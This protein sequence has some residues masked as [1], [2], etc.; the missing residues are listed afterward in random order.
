MANAGPRPKES[1]EAKE[2]LDSGGDGWSAVV[3]VLFHADRTVFL[4]AL[5]FTLNLAL[6]ILAATLIILGLPVNAIDAYASHSRH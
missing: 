3:P 4:D 1:I 5:N 2:K 6:S